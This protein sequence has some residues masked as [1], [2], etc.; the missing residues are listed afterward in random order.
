MASITTS[1]P[2]RRHHLFEFEDLGWFPS[3]FRDT[4]TS[5]LADAFVGA[6]DPVI[7]LILRLLDSEGSNQIVDLCAGGSGP[8]EYLKEQLDNARAEQ[9]HGRTALTLTDL[10]PNVPAFTQAA[11]RL[12]PNV[13]FR[14]DRVDARH[15]PADLKGV[16]TLFTSFH[17]LDTHDAQAVLADAARAGQAIGVFD[18]TQRDWQVIRGVLWQVPLSM[19]RS[20]H[21]WKP[22]RR[23]QMFFTYVVPLTVLTSLWDAVVSQLRAYLPSDLAAMT[24]GLGGEGYHWET[25]QA[26]APGSDYRITY[27]IGHPVGLGA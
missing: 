10:F 17:H 21:K 5:W 24:A 7:P 19:F 15:V 3:L 12:G 1:R 11:T 20:I 13:D 8:W 14:S 27:V 4:I 6:Y 18:F 25:G 22:R 26:T 16:R 23:S 9:G 2:A